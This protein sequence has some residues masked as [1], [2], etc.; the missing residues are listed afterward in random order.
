MKISDAGRITHLA[1]N[2][3]GFPSERV[4]GR[5]GSLTRRRERAR[6]KGLPV[7]YSIGQSASLTRTVTTEDVAAFARLSGD[8]N[9]VHLDPVY[10]ATTRFA[11][12]IA[13]GAIGLAYISAVLGS[14]FPG[15]GTIYLSQKASFKKPVF[16]GD[17]LTVTVTVTGYRP[18]RAILTLA[19]QVTNAD[20]ATVVEGEAICLVTDVVD[21]ISI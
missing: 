11:R 19:T 20:G 21:Q 2:G 9:P 17:T 6:G 12:P 18:E 15:P 5:L 16:H 3:S 7:D 13:H 1:V 14:K 8:T 4:E 10:A